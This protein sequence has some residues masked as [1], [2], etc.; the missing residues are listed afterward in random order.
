M[1]SPVLI[2]SLDL[3]HPLVR[4]EREDRR[5][6][7][8]RARRRQRD[9]YVGLVRNGEIL[10]EGVV[11][12]RHDD[13]HEGECQ[14]RDEDA[15]VEEQEAAAEE[16]DRR[17]RGVACDQ[18]NRGEDDESRPGN[19]D[20]G[21][22]GSEDEREDDVSRQTGTG[23]C[24]CKSPEIPRQ[25]VSFR[26]EVEGGLSHSNV[27]LLLHPSFLGWGTELFKKG[28]VVETFRGAFGGGWPGK[29]AKLRYSA[30]RW[31][32]GHGMVA[33][34][35]LRSNAHVQSTEMVG[36]ERLRAKRE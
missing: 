4:D 20:V 35:L 1:L 19:F 15:I 32:F 24:Q 29:A 7:G 31:D 21:F 28:G 27:R 8:G 17:S 3:V 14:D 6:D 23:R 11:Q 30:V 18:E 9:V 13:A 26:V 34:V 25:S 36:L 16:G 22:V 5:G 33:F 12:D 2:Q 10:V